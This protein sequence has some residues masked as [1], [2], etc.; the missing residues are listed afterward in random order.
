MASSQASRVEE[1]AALQVFLHPFRTMGFALLLGFLVILLALVIDAWHFHANPD[2]GVV[3]LHQL[4]EE[5]MADTTRNGE[6]TPVTAVAVQAVRCV[7]GWIALVVP[8]RGGPVTVPTD[9][10]FQR[11]AST[12]DAN[13]GLAVS[14]IQLVVLR[15]VL[16]IASLP[17]ILFASVLGVADGLVAR[18]I[19]RA[20]AGRE[21]A[22]LFLRA[23]RLH[24]VGLTTVISLFLALPVSIHPVSIFLPYALWAALLSRLRWKYYKKYL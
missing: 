20:N 8:P 7:S 11:V 19:R 13:T 22:H 9:V 14:V 21:S 17:I 12:L 10:P 23:K 2:D 16:V 18:A 24:W 3:T 6:I 5:G 15:A 1:P 4:L